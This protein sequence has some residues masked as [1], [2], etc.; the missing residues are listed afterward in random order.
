LVKKGALWGWLVVAALGC[1]RS[2]GPSAPPTVAP[3]SADPG[4]PSAIDRVTPLPSPLPEIVARVNGQAIRMVQVLGLARKALE[5]SK[6]REKD[7]PGAVRQAMQQYI[8]RELLFQ[9]AMSRGVSADT[10][11]VEAAYD[12][13]RAGFK[14]EAR[15]AASLADQGLDPQSYK[16]ELRVQETVNALLAAVGATVT[17][18]D[19]EAQGFF[20]ANAHAFDPGEKIEVRHILFRILPGAS[21]QAKEGIRVKAGIAANRAAAG[22]DFVGLAKELS[23][24]PETR[25]RGRLLEIRRGM[26]PEAFEQAAFALQP[27]RT[28]GIVET[29][30]GLSVIKLEKRTPG[31]PVRFEDVRD[32]VRAELLR[33]KRQAGFQFLVNALR[34]KAKIETYL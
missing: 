31:P 22:E 1:S 3:P 27:G 7:T 21:A 26:M 9:E 15:F 25:D 33:Q 6:E 23:E 17:V 32:E 30:V 4:A 12:K 16:Q 8:V 11:Q 29:P 24:D 34:A 13:V 28:S 10:K 5:G 20:E 2:E 14:D 18:A 19:A